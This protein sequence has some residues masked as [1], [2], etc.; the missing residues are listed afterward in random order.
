MC[1]EAPNLAPQQTRPSHSGCSSPSMGRVAD[2][3]SLGAALMRLIRY[4]SEFQE[5]VMALHRGAIEGFTLGMSQEEDE[6]DLFAVQD[7]YLHSRGE[8]LLGFIGER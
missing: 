3:V 2:L 5:L 1:N 7:V 6:A 4:Q 8:F